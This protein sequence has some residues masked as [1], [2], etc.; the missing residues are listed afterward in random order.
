MRSTLVL[1]LLLLA[2]CLSV[3]CTIAPAFA[4][5]AGTPPMKPDGMGFATP[6]RDSTTPPGAAGAGMTKTI[7]IVAVVVAVAAI[8]VALAMKKKGTK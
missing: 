5:G 8:G 1:A 4:Q 2:F 6:P 7:I 3:L